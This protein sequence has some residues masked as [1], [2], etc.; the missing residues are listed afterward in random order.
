MDIFK[1]YIL[2]VTIAITVAVVFGLL[3]L[4]EWKDIKTPLGERM[5]LV[6]NCIDETDLSNL[7]CMDL[8]P[9]DNFM[10]RPIINTTS[11]FN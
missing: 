8:Y 10:T 9:V 1:K 5:E 3:T 2:I 11:W 6:Q 4:D 7:E